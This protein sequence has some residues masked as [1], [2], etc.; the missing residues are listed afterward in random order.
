MR[1]AAMI[2]VA[3]G[4]TAESTKNRNAETVEGTSF[5]NPRRMPRMWIELTI[6]VLCIV[7]AV[8]CINLFM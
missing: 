7:F 3:D 6:L 5:G 8:A 2:W 4:T 1:R